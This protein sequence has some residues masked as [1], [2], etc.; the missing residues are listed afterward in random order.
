MNRDPIPEPRHFA[1]SDG[2]GRGSRFGV[3]LPLAAA[4]ADA[5]H[6]GAGPHAAGDPAAEPAPRPVRVLVVDDNVDAAEALAAFLEIEGCAA[7]VATDPLQA[8]EM[9]DDFEPEVAILDIGLPQM[10]GYELAA[11]IRATE[12]GRACRLIAVT[13]YGM[14]DDRA[15]TQAAGF[16]THL[17]KPVDLDALLRAVRPA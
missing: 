1:H 6:G 8:L 10:D 14:D 13:G 4:A 9:L 5:D 3:R 17:V 2:V 7:R 16:E 12:S 15:R 11:R